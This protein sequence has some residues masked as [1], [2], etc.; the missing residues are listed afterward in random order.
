MNCLLD[1]DIT[2]VKAPIVSGRGVKLS[3]K[4]AMGVLVRE[5]G[6]GSARVFVTVQSGHVYRNKPL[7][8]KHATF[9]SLLLEKRVRHRERQ[10]SKPE[11]EGH[12]L[13]IRSCEN[14]QAQGKGD[15]K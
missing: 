15:R 6:C 10:Q 11:V 14:P 9:H 1:G 13:D 3:A 8:V 2:V 5:A 4:G 7:L 12:W